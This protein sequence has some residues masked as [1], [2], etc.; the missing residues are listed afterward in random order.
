MERRIS[1]D[2]RPYLEEIERR[3]LLS[4]I[5]DIMAG[6]SIA[7]GR[8]ALLAAT[9]QASEQSVDRPSAESRPVCQS[10]DW[11]GREP[12]PHPHGDTDQARAA[13]RTVHGAVCGHVHGWSRPH[14]RRKHPDVH[15]GG[16][17]G[18]HDAAL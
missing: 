8:G 16:R 9:S 3:E 18:Q 15:H 12:G 14:Q 4:A 13:Q 17:L 6:N 7:A 11:N 10:S 5:T 1:R 2:L